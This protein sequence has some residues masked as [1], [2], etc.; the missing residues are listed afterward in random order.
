MIRSRGLFAPIGDG[1][2]GYGCPTMSPVAAGLIHMEINPGDDSLGAFLAIQ[3]GLVMH[4]IHMFGS[5]EQREKWL[6]RLATTRAVG[7]FALTEPLHG[8]DSVGLEASARRKGD[9]RLLSG[10]KRWIGNASFADVVIV[11]AR[12][13]AD[14]QDKGFL[15]EK[16]SEGFEAEVITGKASVRAVWQSDI[17]LTECRVPRATGSQGR[18]LSRTPVRC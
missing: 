12:D 9:N 7:G 1:I 13:E 3:S 11:W 16:G 4:S 10:V 14:G 8:S 5:E 2:E 17:T 18:A 6:P 15:V